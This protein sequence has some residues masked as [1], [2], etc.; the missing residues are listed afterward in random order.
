MTRLFAPVFNFT[1]LYHYFSYSDDNN[2]DRLSKGSATSSTHNTNATT[3]ATAA[4]TTTT[5]SAS[6]TTSIHDVQVKDDDEDDTWNHHSAS[7]Q[8]GSLGRK[9]ESLEKMKKN[10]NQSFIPSQQQQQLK[11]EQQQNDNH[12]HHQQQQ[13]YSN[14]EDEYLN[15]LVHNHKKVNSSNNN[16]NYNNHSDYMNHSQETS[17]DLLDDT[18]NHD[19]TVSIASTVV[20]ERKRNEYAM[21]ADDSEDEHNEFGDFNRDMR[22][23]NQSNRSDSSLIQRN[24]VENKS[25]KEVSELDE[26]CIDSKMKEII[27]ASVQYMSPSPGRSSFSGYDG[28]SDHD[29][30]EDSTS[31]GKDLSNKNISTTDGDH[32]NTT[33][34]SIQTGKEAPVNLSSSTLSH[35]YPTTLTSELIDATNGQQQSTHVNRRKQTL[36]SVSRSLHTTTSTSGIEELNVSKEEEKGAFSSPLD[37]FEVQLLNGG[38]DVKVV[39]Q[40]SKSPT[41]AVNVASSKNEN[42]TS[43]LDRFQVQVLNGGTEAK[44]M[45]I[46]KE[47]LSAVQSPIIKIKSPSVQHS[48]NMMNPHDNLQPKSHES[49]IKSNINFDVS[50]ALKS[51]KV[52]AKTSMPKAEEDACLLSSSLASSFEEDVV[53][54]SPKQSIKHSNTATHEENK[55]CETPLGRESS[56]KPSTAIRTPLAAAWI[57]KNI[58]G[59]KDRLLKVLSGGKRIPSS[60][61]SRRS[62]SSSLSSSLLSKTIEDTATMREEKTLSSEIKGNTVQQKSSLSEDVKKKKVL[63]KTSTKPESIETLEQID[64]TRSIIKSISPEEYQTS[65]RV[66]QIQV[67]LDELGRAVNVLNEWAK[68]NLGESNS[69]NNNG[70]NGDIKSLYLDEKEANVLLEKEF[71]ATRKAKS[72]LMSLCFFRR[73]TLQLSPGNT[74]KH[75]VIPLK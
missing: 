43:P 22:M 28:N 8:V 25:N 35:V 21:F 70:R 68:T 45:P 56:K 15:L 58:P 19:G 7:V 48:Q 37:K 73:I 41:N 26:D 40:K 32:S 57:K 74:N 2:F 44:V 60:P 65:P 75:F 4:T 49:D 50:P 54:L 10:L 5:T 3:T 30:D 24:K 52:Y 62:S 38:R 14:V 12:H 27:E 18:Y 64:E 23:K 42:V 33:R 20:C 9:M 46:E 29:D 69:N 72:L 39:S 13:H 36:D 16:Q 51:K 61:S 55:P 1:I 66:V 63:E 6:A 59:D 17:M 31:S 47:F 67:T 71:N 11:E 34:R 53:D